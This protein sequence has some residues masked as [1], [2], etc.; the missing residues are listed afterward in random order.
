AA[1]LP[2]HETNDAVSDGE[3]ATQSVSVGN[4]APTV[5]LSAGNELTV[6]EGSTKTYSYTI[7]DPGADSVSSV[8]TSCG[9][10]GSKSNDTHTNSAGSFDCSFPDGPA[11]ST[12]SAQ[13]TDSDGDTGNT[14]TQSVTVNNVAPTVTLS[15][16]NHLS[17][18]E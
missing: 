2:T 15:N 18:A 14:D 3:T 4:S 9:A 10:N 11:A 8:D 17:V 7:S 5:T 16:L 13:A 1:A 6:A 12:V